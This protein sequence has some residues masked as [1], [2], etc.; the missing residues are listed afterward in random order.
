MEYRRLNE[1]TIG[2]RCP[3]PNITYLLDKLGRYQYFTSLE[4]AADFRQIEIEEID[5]PQ[6]AFSTFST[7][8]K[9]L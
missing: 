3:I 7:V 1:K 2:D 6:T 8:T 9:S 4:L 5:I